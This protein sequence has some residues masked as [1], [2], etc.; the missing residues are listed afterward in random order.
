MRVSTTN[1]KKTTIK[2]WFYPLV[3]I[4]SVEFEDYANS[5][6]NE[7]FGGGGFEDDDEE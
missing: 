1:N 3:K 5:G 4:D 2:K 7:E 6:N